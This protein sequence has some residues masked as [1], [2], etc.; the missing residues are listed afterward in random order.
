MMIFARG[1]LCMNFI[2]MSTANLVFITL[3]T[4]FSLVGMMMGG[5]EKNV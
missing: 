2:V 1:R 4:G 5:M 3:S